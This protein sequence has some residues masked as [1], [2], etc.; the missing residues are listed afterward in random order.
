M[1]SEWSDMGFFQ[2]AECFTGTPDPT[3]P[4][5]VALVVPYRE[6]QAHQHAFEDILFAHDGQNQNELSSSDM[7]SMSS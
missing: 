6:S 3:H 5:N 1:A 4:S 2:I 7:S